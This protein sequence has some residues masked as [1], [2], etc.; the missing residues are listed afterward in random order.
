MRNGV[1]MVMVMLGVQ[2]SLANHLWAFAVGEITVY[3]H[4]GEPFA[5]EVRLLLGPRERDKAVEV[6]LGNQ[7]VYRVEG[8]RRVAML[9][10]LKAVMVP[11]APDMIR[12]SSN[13]P[14]QESAFDLVL[15]IRAGQVTIV[16]HYDVTL[17]PPVPAAS[18]VGAQL[19]TVAQ[20]TALTHAPKTLAK[21]TR[22]PRRTQR[23]GPVEKGE[24][25][26]TIAK[27][28]HVPNEKIWQAVVALWRANQ[29]RFFAGNLHGLQVGT[30]LDVPSDLT[31]N[32][33][34]MGLVEAQEV[35]ANQ[36]EEWHTPRHLG[37]GKQRV[38]VA[39]DT[40]TSAPT[41][42]KRSGVATAAGKRAAAI[43][44]E[45][46]SA[47]TPT[48]PQEVVLPAGKPGNLVSMT[49][50][51]TVLQGLE[52]RLM[53][54]LTPT[55]QIQEVKSAPTFVSTTELQ[56]SIQ[57]LEERLMQRMQHML[58][59]TPTPEPVRVGQRPLQ[60][61]PQAVQQTPTV[62]AAQPASTQLVPYLL[63]L[64]NALCLVLIGVLGWLWLRHRDRAER[65]QRL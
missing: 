34:A 29:G 25:L 4:R 15:S 40:A 13:V 58:I 64:T 21:P 53:Q 45:E 17:P 46:Q 16:K 37:T 36:W 20:V 12:L 52:E 59:Q 51:Q 1:R 42:T 41:P 5:A 62:E 56:A 39:R 47:E 57:S 31:E 6:T 54:R 8:L 7:E 48:A 2:L 63:G 26:Y 44:P 35:V 38:S 9:D 50:L 24:S 60:Q 55:A 22:R 10:T 23:Y 65:L 43:P 14:I 61:A 27:A 11:G 32:M 18:Q 28:L 30:F 19:P 49:E 3:S 33:A